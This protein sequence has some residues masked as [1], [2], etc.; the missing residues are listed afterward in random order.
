MQARHSV[1]DPNAL[2]VVPHLSEQ[3]YYPR[4]GQLWRHDQPHGRLLGPP[5]AVRR[6]M[7]R[8][9]RARYHHHQPTAPKVSGATY[10]YIA[11]ITMAIQNA[12]EK[13]ITLNG[14]YQFIMD[15]FPLLQGEQAGLAKQ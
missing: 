4:G 15:R 6:G 7:G 13:K 8:S 1:S 10:S 11:L 3:N 9:L 14:I 5:G 12:P 2:G